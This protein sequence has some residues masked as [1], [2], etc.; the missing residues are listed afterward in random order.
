[1]SWIGANGVLVMK[2]TE[3]ANKWDDQMARVFG[4]KVDEPSLREIRSAGVAKPK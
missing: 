2:W 4:E 1:M 3:Y